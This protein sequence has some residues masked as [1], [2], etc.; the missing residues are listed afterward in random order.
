MLS[1]SLKTRID[2]SAYS[3]GPRTL[4]LIVPIFL[5]LNNKRQGNYVV[6]HSTFL[7]LKVQQIFISGTIVT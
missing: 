3:Q 5:G 1:D 7:E 4:Q 6:S 2:T